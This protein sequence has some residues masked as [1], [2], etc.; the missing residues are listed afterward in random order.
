M[1]KV[2]PGSDSLPVPSG[3]HNTVIQGPGVS[4]APC[5]AQVSPEPVLTKH[6]PPKILDTTGQNRSILVS[7]LCKGT[8]LR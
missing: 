7:W 1:F 5:Q 3:I 4:S 6:L 2:A 8:S